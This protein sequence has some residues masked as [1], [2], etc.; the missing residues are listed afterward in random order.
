MKTFRVTKS[1]AGIETGKEI[2]INDNCLN[3]I[4]HMTKY[5]YWEA[6]PEK[7][8]EPVKPEIK[9]PET[10][11]IAPKLQNKIPRDLKRRKRK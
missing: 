1:Y 9:K 7:N 11:E 3:T 10:K 4:K 5:G 6:V 8:P 2:S